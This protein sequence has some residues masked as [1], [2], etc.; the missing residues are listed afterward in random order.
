M[1]VNICTAEEGEAAG[2][3]AII[4]CRGKKESMKSRKLKKIMSFVLASAMTLSLA[5]CGDT[6]GNNGEQGNNVGNGTEVKEF[7]YV[8]EFLE[9]QEENVSYYNMKYVGDS[10]YYESYS[11][12]EATG[13]SSE[14]I[15]KYSLTDKTSSVIPIQLGEEVSLG[16]YAILSD[17]SIYAICNDYSGE[18]GPEGYTE[19]KRMLCKFGADGTEI[20]AKDLAEDMPQDMENTYIQYIAVDGENRLYLSA[21]SKILLLDAEGNYQGTVDTGENWI[22]SMGCGKDGKVYFSYYDN[23]A[24]ELSFVLAAVDFDKRA[25]GESYKGFISGNGNG[26]Y[27]GRDHDFLIGS[28]S[29]VYCYDLQ[30]Q[31]SEKLFDW[32][33][34]DINGNNATCMGQLEDGRILA[35]INDWENNDNGIALLTKTNASEVAPRETIVIGAMYS[36]S[37]LQSAAVKFNK[38]NDKYRI[39][40]RTYMD[41]MSYSETAYNDAVTRMNNDI[42]SNNCPDIIDLRNVNI[43]RLAAKGVFEDLNPYLESS[44]LNRDDF[45]ES[46]IEAYTY[47]DVLVSIPANFQLQTVVGSASELGGKEGWTIDEMIAY[48]DEYPDAQLFDYSDKDSILSLC[49]M[50]NESSFIDWST[51]ECRFDT[52]EFKSLLAFVNR[53][54]DEYQYEDGGASTPTRIQNREIL[55]DRAYIYDFNEIQ[56]YMEMFGGD[57][58]CIGYPTTDGSSG[59]GIMAE[60]AYAI[61]SKSSKKD[62]AWQFI[63]GILTPVEDENENTRGGMQWWGFPNNRK[64]LSAMAEEAVEVE[65]LT[66]ENGELVKDENG[67]PIPM[68]GGGGVGYED[69]WSY[70]YRIPTQEEVDII[71]NLIENAR[72]VAGSSDEILKIISEEAAPYFHGQKS[73]D[74]AAAI[75]QSRINIYVSE[76]S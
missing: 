70:T 25:V 63:E 14:N 57:V 39:S 71:L 37:Q 21:D 75:I 56:L 22:N 65:Y 43:Q 62:G 41:I 29:S 60:Q 7:V 58:A 18:P 42:T 45:V 12:D 33:D 68:G 20:F 15:V 34:S 13:M 51:G 32:L 2:C 17:G 69:G 67:D 5:A 46:I 48:A 54:P 8:P 36:S 6:Q 26:L 4:V 30:S 10:L 72:A 38:S 52:P 1:S 35:V 28:G 47:D 50:F 73:V 19:P 16:E 24:E 31:K 61:T 53:F 9:I 74:E 44:S 49:M 40:I 76:N 64:S 66:D 27:A 11:F 55:L 3:A 59:T 23:T